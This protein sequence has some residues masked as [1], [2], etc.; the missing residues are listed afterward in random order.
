M[1]VVEL[2]VGSGS[3]GVVRV[4]CVSVARSKGGSVGCACACAC[5][6]GRVEV[7]LLVWPRLVVDGRCRVL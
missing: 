1:S 6:E 2:F 3:V 7:V 4:V 5:G